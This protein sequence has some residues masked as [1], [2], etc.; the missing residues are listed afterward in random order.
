M[1]NERVLYECDGVGFQGELYYEK[2]GKKPCVLVAHAW[3]GQDDFA[4]EKAKSLAKLG[5]VGFAVDLYGEAKNAHSADEAVKLMAPLFMDRKL[6]QNRLKAAFEV[7]KNHPEVDAA[8]I[9]GIGFCFGG[10]SI[11]ELFR[12]G[13]DVKGVVSFHAVLGD[14][15]EG[16]GLPLF[17]LLKISKARSLF[18]MDM[19]I[20]L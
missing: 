13:V 16:K 5:Y 7:A 19:M 1:K 3:M 4:R 17:L 11:I 14:E 2:P 10:L 18:Y 15:K 6:L 9:G 20:R 12:S 8:R